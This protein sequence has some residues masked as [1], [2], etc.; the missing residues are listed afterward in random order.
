MA[1][2]AQVKIARGKLLA[3]NE[4]FHPLT[5]RSAPSDAWHRRNSARLAIRSLMASRFSGD[6]PDAPRITLPIQC[7]PGSAARM[8]KKAPTSR[9][10]DK[11]SRLFFEHSTTAAVALRGYITSSALRSALADLPRLLSIWCGGGRSHP[12]T[13]IERI[14]RWLTRFRDCRSGMG[15]L[16]SGGNMANIVGFFVARRAK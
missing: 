7:R 13:E 12:T 6:L 4:G 10:L 8:R 16:V 11:F 1:G 5:K 15:V 3:V 14:I 2:V 9:P